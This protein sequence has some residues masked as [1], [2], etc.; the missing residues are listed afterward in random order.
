MAGSGRSER[1]IARMNG[2]R[3][4]ADA[5]RDRTPGAKPAGR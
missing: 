3:A 4:L 1:L 5:E 2:I